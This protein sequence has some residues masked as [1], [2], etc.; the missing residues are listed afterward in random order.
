MLRSVGDLCETLGALH[1]V[2]QGPLNFQDVIVLP[3]SDINF[4][5]GELGNL[6]LAA[7]TIDQS[8]SIVSIFEFLRL[9]YAALERDQL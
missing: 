7:H 3:N 8:L 6:S 5:L 1:S 4:H 2:I 9:V